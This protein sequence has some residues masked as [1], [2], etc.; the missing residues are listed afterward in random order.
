MAEFRKDQRCFFARGRHMLD[1]EMLNTEKN[2]R[3]FCISFILSKNLEIL[4]ENNFEDVLSQIEQFFLKETKRQRMVKSRD[5]F[6]K[7]FMDELFH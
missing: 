5:A 3:V 4:D 7:N 6:K 1:R 2:E